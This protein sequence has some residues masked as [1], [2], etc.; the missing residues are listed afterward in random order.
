MRGT[1]AKGKWKN[2]K[3]K[4]IAYSLLANPGGMTL[5]AYYASCNPSDIIDLMSRT[6]NGLPWLENTGNVRQAFNG[7]HIA[8]IKVGSIDDLFEGDEDVLIVKD[9]NT[10]DVVLVA[11]SHYCEVFRAQYLVGVSSAHRTTPLLS[12]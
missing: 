1:L 8:Q 3:G 4:V 7:F 9:I 5:N 10:P 2:L 12:K 6:S 11:L